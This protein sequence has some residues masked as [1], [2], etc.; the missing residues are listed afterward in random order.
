MSLIAGQGVF[1]AASQG[2]PTIAVANTSSFCSSAGTVQ[3]G[4]RVNNDGTIDV[5]DNCGV[6][7]FDHDYLSTTGAGEGDPFEVQCS[8]NSGTS[9][10]SGPTLNTYHALTANRTWVWS[11]T[12]G[13]FNSGSWRITVREVADTGNNDFGDY[14][15]DTEDGS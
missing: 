4:I 1:I 6:F 9:P 11:A 7:S 13:E 12:P 14:T 2:L 15:W 10:S 3:V 8:V 5:R